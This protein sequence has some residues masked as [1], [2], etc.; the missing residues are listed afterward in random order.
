MGGCSNGSRNVWRGEFFVFDVF[1][2]RRR[3]IHHFC[4]RQRA[5]TFKSRGDVLTPEIF[6]ERSDRTD[7]KELSL[8]SKEKYGVHFLP[9]SDD[10]DVFFHR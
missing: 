4:C 8:F 6:H 9:Q 7:S 1:S 2:Q 3:R 5:V 10:I